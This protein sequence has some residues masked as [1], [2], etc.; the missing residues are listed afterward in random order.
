MSEHAFTALKLC[1]SLMAGWA[2]LYALTAVL[3]P[4]VFLRH[5]DFMD[6]RHRKPSVL[7]FGILALRPTRLNTTFSR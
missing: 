5:F 1:L 2:A 7:S 4:K 6:E 3:W